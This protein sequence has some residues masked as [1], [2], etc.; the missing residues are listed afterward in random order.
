MREPL[1]PFLTEE[2]DG[3]EKVW[4]YRK[5]P[6][7][8][9]AARATATDATEKAERPEFP[10][11]LRQFAPPQTPRAAPLSPS[12]AFDEEIGRFAHAAGSPADRQKALERGRIVHRLMQALPDIPPARRDDA[13][14]RYLANTAKD[15]LPAE[16]AEIARQ[17]FAVLDDPRFAEVFAPGSRPEVPIVGRIPCPGTDPVEIAGQ[18]DRLIVTEGAVLIAD[19]KTD[20]TVPQKLADVPDYVTQL[21]LYRAVLARLYPQKRIRAALI[22]TGCPILIEVPA[23]AMDAALAA[24]LGKVLTRSRHA[25]VKVP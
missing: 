2:S 22:F 17:V 16:R 6:A 24:E 3:V 23:T 12:A 9:V 14:T 4:R 25:A 20:R 10:S 5:T 13:L 8:P 21:A 7:D 15:F 1:A 18:V 11:W 19:Y